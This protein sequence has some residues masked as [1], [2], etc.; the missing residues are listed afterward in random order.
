MTRPTKAA[1]AK[2]INDL[3]AAADARG[4]FGPS[5]HRRGSADR[6]TVEAIIGEWWPRHQRR[7]AESTRLDYQRVL[8]NH[9][10][11][12][13]GEIR[14]GDLHQRDLVRLYDQLLAG[15]L[16]EA[17]IRRVHMVLALVCK[18]A[19][20]QDIISSSPGAK[21]EPPAVREKPIDPPD[22]VDVRRL[23]KVDGEIRPGFAAFVR[24]AAITGARRGELA[25]LRVDDLA[26]AVVTIARSISIA[27][28]EHGVGTN[29]IEK[30]TKTHAIRRVTIDHGTRSVLDDHLAALG[31]R[32]DAAEIEL[33]GRHFVFTDSLDGAK[34]WRPEIIS[35]D[36]NRCVKAAGLDGVRLH[37]LRHAAATA[38]MAAGVDVVT[39][40]SRLGHKRRDTF[41]NRY[42]HAVSATDGHAADALAGHLDHA[43][44]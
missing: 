27:E 37:D 30:D 22:A 41:L 10:V 40:A 43:P 11:P 34:P 28:G 4:E 35:R 1:A 38:M 18:Y 23:L 3:L 29:L 32:A 21:A 12:N 7:L 33:V 25:A 5:D 36:F 24:L 8:D 6:L 39:G 17:R 9:I 19:V 14:I 31:H 13:L 26:G 2:A 20:R 42:S 16:S 15:G 44:R